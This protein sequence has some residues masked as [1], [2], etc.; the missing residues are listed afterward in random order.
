MLQSFSRQV[1]WAKEKTDLKTLPKWKPKSALGVRKMFKA[2]QH[3][4]A[5]DD[6]DDD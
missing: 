1:F 5:D 2:M 4:Y 6:D 3:M